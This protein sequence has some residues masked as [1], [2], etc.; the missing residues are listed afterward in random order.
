MPTIQQLKDELL[1]AEG[2]LAQLTAQR[3]AHTAAMERATPA[4]AKRFKVERSYVGPTVTEAYALLADVETTWKTRV[5]ETADRRIALER[6]EVEE[7]WAKQRF[8]E[9]A[10]D[11]AAASEVQRELGRLDAIIKAPERIEEVS[12]EAMKAAQKRVA[13]ARTA[14][15]NAEA[16]QVVKADEIVVTFTG[17]NCNCNCRKP[18]TP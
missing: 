13:D 9:A 12:A 16:G 11:L 3:N 10:A 6:A 14:L 5:R 18:K 4:M 2:R 7:D 15:E 1:E 17:Y 8:V